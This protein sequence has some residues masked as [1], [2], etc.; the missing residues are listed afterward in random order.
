MYE[1]ISPKALQP[2]CNCNDQ[3]LHHFIY[4]FIYLF[5]YF[6]I[7]IC[8]GTQSMYVFACNAGNCLKEYQNPCHH[9]SRH[10]NE[11]HS[12]NLVTPALP[13][14]GVCCFSHDINAGIY[15][16]ISSMTLPPCTPWLYLLWDQ[17]KD[18]RVKK[19]NTFLVQGL[20]HNWSSLLTQSR[21]HTIISF[22]GRICNSAQTP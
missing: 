11:T 17:A 16:P 9:I 21:N 3:H 20:L 15:W 19:E 22:L 4:F 6:I 12:S 1:R 18:V 14:V 2:V 7:Y 10:D 5:F 8:W 13:C